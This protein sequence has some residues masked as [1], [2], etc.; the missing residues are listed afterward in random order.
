MARHIPAVRQ[1][2][3]YSE[4][5]GILSTYLNEV[6]LR[7]KLKP[8]DHEALTRKARSG[9]EEAKKRMIECNLRLVVR[10]AKQY[11]KRGIEFMDLIAEGNIGLM[12]AVEGFE[13]DM[14]Y[15]FST[16]A[17]WWVRHFI[18]RAIANNSRLVRLPVRVSTEL[19][20]MESAVADLRKKLNRKPTVVEIAAA[21]HMKI[22]QVEKLS[23]LRHS[24]IYTDTPVGEGETSTL[25]ESLADQRAIDP[26]EDINNSDLRRALRKVLAKLSDR[27]RELLMLRYGLGERETETLNRIGSDWNLTRERVRQIQRNTLLKVREMMA[28]EGI[29]VEAV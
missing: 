27:E 15:K 14:G 6:G 5:S 18:E 8:G 16:Y 4:T 22:S 9:D 26:A 28:C 17:V 23:T 10:I 20:R 25:G 1:N 24:F 29:T 13:P 3:D 11:T 7:P 19:S 21:A 12:R 2:G